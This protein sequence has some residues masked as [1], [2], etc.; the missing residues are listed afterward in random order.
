MKCSDTRHL[1]KNGF[2]TSVGKVSSSIPASPA[3][4]AELHG[5]SLVVSGPINVHLSIPFPNGTVNF[6]NPVIW[7]SLDLFC[8]LSTMEIH[9]LVLQ[10]RWL[11]QRMMF[12][13]M[14]SLQLDLVTLYRLSAPWASLSV[15]FNGVTVLMTLGSWYEKRSSC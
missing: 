6:L 1:I 2:A 9:A 10:D 3:L 15:I 14:L 13:Q 8:M 5:A 4:V 12:L 7:M 11:G